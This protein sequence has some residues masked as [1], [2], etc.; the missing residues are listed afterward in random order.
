MLHYNSQKTTTCPELNVSGASTIEYVLV[1]LHCQITER[2]LM[3]VITDVQ[4]H[5]DRPLY[6][7]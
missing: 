7:V 4:K 2:H 5:V 3:F 1:N 6:Q